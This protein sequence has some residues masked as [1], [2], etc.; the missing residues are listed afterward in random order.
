MTCSRERS[1][2]QFSCS[3]RWAIRRVVGS[4]PRLTTRGSQ[5]PGPGYI[6]SAGLFS[7]VERGRIRCHDLRDYRKRVAAQEATKIG[8]VGRCLQE[9]ADQ[10]WYCILSHCIN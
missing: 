2:E 4:L 5:Q 8:T 9:G 7:L 3:I 10:V 1:R 6:S